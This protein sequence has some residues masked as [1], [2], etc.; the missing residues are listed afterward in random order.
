VGQGL[1]IRD[2]LD[3]TEQLATVG[4]NP[5]GEWSACC[6]DLYLTTHNTHSRQTSMPRVEF[7]PII[8]AGD[9]ATELR[10]RLHGHWYRLKLTR[11]HVICWESRRC[12]GRNALKV[13]EWRANGPVSTWLIYLWKTESWSFYR[14]FFVICRIWIFVAMLEDPSLD[15]ILSHMNV[16]NTLGPFWVPFSGAFAEFRK[17]IVSFVL[18]LRPFAWNNLGATGQIF[19]KFCIRWFFEEL[20]RKFKLH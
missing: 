16:V 7:K 4:R 18:S 20:S 19:L 8:S 1:L 5:L 3:H 17:A 11:W 12:G 6:R 2:V 10:L 13:K 9:G 15:H 14:K